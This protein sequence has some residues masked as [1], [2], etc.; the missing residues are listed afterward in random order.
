M[1]FQLQI[2]DFL[3]TSLVLSSVFIDKMVEFVILSLSIAGFLHLAAVVRSILALDALQ[4][5]LLVLG[6]TGLYMFLLL[7]VIA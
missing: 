6:F 2:L 1:Q 7:L 5:Q 3:G 4:V